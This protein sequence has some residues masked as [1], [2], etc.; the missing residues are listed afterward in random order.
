MALM[1]VSGHSVVVAVPLAG[2]AWYDRRRR[3]HHNPAPGLTSAMVAAV[4]A[5]AR[6]SPRW[7]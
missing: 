3:P 5:G 7:V 6:R 2:V 1:T 4:G